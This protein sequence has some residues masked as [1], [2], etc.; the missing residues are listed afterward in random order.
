VHRSP[1][2][3]LEYEELERALEKSGII[4]EHE[5]SGCAKGE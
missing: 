1:R 3:R 2:E 4:A 5:A